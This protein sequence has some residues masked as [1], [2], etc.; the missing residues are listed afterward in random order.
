[1]TK[2]ILKRF[3]GM[4]PTLLIITTVAFIIMRIAPGGPFDRERAIPPAVQANIEA[5]YHLDEPL[6]KQYFR[7]LG[8]IIRGDFGPSYKYKDQ[9]VTDLISNS[10][11]HSLLL[12]TLALMAATF[13][14]VLAG[15]IAALNQNTWLDYTAMSIAVFGVSVPAFVI[16]PVLMLIF[17]MK[18]KILPTSGW[19]TGPDGWKTVLMPLIALSMSYFASIAR[20]SRSSV[21]EV[22]RSDYVRTAKAKGLSPTMIILKHVLKGAMLPVVSYL[23]IAYSGIITGSVVIEQIFRIPGLGRFFVQSSLN[24][25]YTMIMGVIIVYSTVVILMNFLVDILY[26]FLDPRISYQ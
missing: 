14:G 17:A 21:L 5:K 24:R 12:G 3:L 26:S 16:G 7:Y 8:G 10:L 23:G 2:Y 13:F 4:I 22:I 9:T 18:L 6:I 1:M 20:L 15:I 11:P 19:I 25:D